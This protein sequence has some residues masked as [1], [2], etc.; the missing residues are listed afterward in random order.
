MKRMEKEDDRI[1]REQ[2]LAVHGIG[3]ETADSILLYALKKPVFVIDAYT[4]RILSR[5]G[6][7]GHDEPYP[8][9]Q[10]LFHSSLERDVE[11]YN[12]YHALFVA[13]GKSF[14]RPKTRCTECPLL[15]LEH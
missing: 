6:I 2:L 13:T 12:E 11:L 14:C 1:L 15:S 5:H 7:M 8:D 3:P 4:K 9:F 10:E